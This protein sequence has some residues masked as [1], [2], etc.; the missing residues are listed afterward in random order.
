MMSSSLVQKQIIFFILTMLLFSQTIAD[1]GLGRL[2]FIS[3][4]CT[5]EC[6]IWGYNVAWDNTGRFQ[7]FFSV[8]SM[9]QLD[10]LWIICRSSRVPTK[11]NEFIASMHLIF[12]ISGEGISCIPWKWGTAF[13]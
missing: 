10:F 4:S 3:S 12:G 8:Y 13:V 1:P 2:E 6:E 7:R 11:D 5:A 9:F